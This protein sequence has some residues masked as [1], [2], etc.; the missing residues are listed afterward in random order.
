MDGGDGGG[1]SE[2]VDPGPLRSKSSA[3][4]LIHTAVLLSKPI[5]PVYIQTYSVIKVSNRR[6][7]ILWTSLFP[8][9]NL[10]VFDV[11]LSSPYVPFWPN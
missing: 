9:D 11:C 7:M 6:N 3:R 8:L 4:A 10:P 1:R 2:L 5:L